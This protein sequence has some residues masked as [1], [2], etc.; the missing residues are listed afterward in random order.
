[1]FNAFERMMALRYL[2]ARRKEGFVSVIA[3]FSLAGIALGVATLI[4]VMA[5]MNGFRQ[6]LMGRILGF[7]GHLYVYGATDTLSDYDAL[8]GQVHEVNGVVTVMPT[9]E[10]QVMVSAGNE[11][12]GAM[13]RGVPA[14]GL[15]DRPMIARNV[16]SGSIADLTG[17]D[18]AMIGSRLAERLGLRLGDGITLISPKGKV[19]AFGSVPRI[20][21]YSIVAIYEVGMYE[22]DSNFVFLPLEAAQIYF[23]MPNAVSYL[24]VVVNDPDNVR[25]VTGDLAIAPLNQGVRLRDWRQTNSTFFNALQVERNVMFLILTLIIVVAAFNIISGLIMLVKDK[26]RDIAILRTMGATRGAVMRVFFLAGASVGITGTTVGLFLGVLFCW[27][28]ES[29]RQFLQALT[30][31]ELFS[32][33]IY[34]LSQM[35][36]EMDPTEVISV[37]LMSLGLSLAATLYPSWRA[38]RTDPVEALRYE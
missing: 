15:M 30:G 11:S 37:A 19:T 36:A 31:T 13:V 28:I 18:A 8:A 16:I 17:R 7:N 23:Q 35:P 34:F 6:D 24:D 2:R 14:E 25:T 29:I 3:G 33:E 32:P 27:N 5:V 21:T 9:I 38:A 22:F 10:G 26:G 20:K 1:M 4:I 12:R